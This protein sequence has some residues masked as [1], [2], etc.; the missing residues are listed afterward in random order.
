VREADLSGA[1]LQGALL[2]D[3]DLTDADLIGCR[4]HGVSAWR[5]KLERAKQQSLIIT[6]KNEPEITVDNIEVAQFIYLMLNNE[7]VRDVI[8]TIT[9]KDG[10]DPRPLHARAEASSRWLAEWL[11]GATGCASPHRAPGEPLVL[12]RGARQ[13]KAFTCGHG[14]SVKHIRPE[15]HTGLVR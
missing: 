5:V 14:L 15:T 3:T 12:L 7:K 11:M 1:S 10:A 6:D 9:S 2:L 13:R 8:D 4:G